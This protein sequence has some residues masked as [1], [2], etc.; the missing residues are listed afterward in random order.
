MQPFSQ[1]PPTEPRRPGCGLLAAHS[2]AMRTGRM[3]RKDRHASLEANF[4]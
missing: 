2:A 1:S 4:S 3:P